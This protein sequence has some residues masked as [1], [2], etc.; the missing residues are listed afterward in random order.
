VCAEKNSGGENF[1]EI[2]KKFGKFREISGKIRKI[3][4]IRKLVIGQA[5]GRAQ[6]EGAEIGKIRENRG[7]SRNS[8]KIEKYEN[9]GNPPLCNRLKFGGEK[10]EKSGKS[11]KSRKT[12]NPGNP[13]RAEIRARISIY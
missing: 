3:A 5:R 2:W 10:I 11:G 9:P 1:R 6:G 7:K 4:S 8:G 12:R 13:A